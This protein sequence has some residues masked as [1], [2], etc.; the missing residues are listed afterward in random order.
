MNSYLKFLSRNKLYTAIMAVGMA[1]SLAFVIIIGSYIWNQFGTTRF[2]GAD[3]KN[4]YAIGTQEFYGATYG[5]ADEIKGKVPEIEKCARLVDMG[6]AT[7]KINGE[8]IRISYGSMDREFFEIFNEFKL[9]DGNLS[10]L[11]SKTMCLVS[12]SFAEQ[13]SL[14]IGDILNLS[15]G[16]QY[17]L[18]GIVED[19][20]TKS[21]FKA[22]EVY[23][24]LEAGMCTSVT[25]QPFD[26]FGGTLYFLRLRPDAD[27]DE[28]NEKIKTI[29]NGVYPEF[30]TES[31]KNLSLIR[32]DKIFFRKTSY[33][34]DFN[35]GDLGKL[36][37]ILAVG[38]LL[39]LSAIFNY[40][41]L[42][43]AL[44]GKRAKEMATRRLLGATKGD[45]YR[46]NIL[47]SIAF[48]AVCTIL[49]IMLAK[50]LTPT[51]NRLMNSPAVP[52]HISLSAGYL[53]AFAL[54][55][56]I[57]GALSGLLPALMA[58]KNK[59]I[60]IVKGVFRA[61]QK[62]SI[63]KIFII[64]QNA[65][66]VFLISM[67]IVMESQYRKSLNVPAHCNVDDIYYYLGWGEED[68]EILKNTL[69]ALPF[70][71][72][73]GY[74]DRLPFIK[75]SGQFSEDRYGNKIM[76]RKYMVDSLTFNMLDIEILEDFNAP[77]TN[78]VWF[79][80]KAWKASGFD[81]EHHD[82]SVLSER[83][84]GCE[85]LAGIIAGFPTSGENVGE[86]EN[87]ILV[88]CKDDEVDLGYCGLAIKTGPDHKE[89]GKTIEK[90]IEEWDKEK[91][92]MV[93]YS[94]YIKDKIEEDLRPAKN[95][96]RL[97]ELFM[98]IA[99]IIA[100][101]GLLAM[102]SYYADINTKDVAI[103]KVFGSDAGK[104]I[105]KGIKDYMIIVLLACLIGVPLAIYAAGEYLKQF[106]YKI[107]GYG[108]IF[109]VAVL[110][111]LCFAF[112][113]VFWQTRRS[114]LTEPASELKK[115]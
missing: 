76:Y 103:R 15:S 44:S 48:T 46:K 86:E 92:S 37:V 54:L 62:M 99:T 77:V 111:T 67:A 20:G 9:I 30:F 88:V 41:N 17:S 10:A 101:L 87:V 14:K 60:D 110:I 42:S 106:T 74:A 7:L 59:P 32:L 4:I 97:V 40:V 107:E 65:L 53:A 29:A 43:L 45:I 13:H 1:V 52:A 22:R 27:A 98:A 108:W 31:I 89:A 47:E 56:I 93:L 100:L 105:K 51:F 12:E 34:P 109:V 18:G 71:E 95:N 49:A 72:E 115:E 8:N 19:F 61:K 68:K 33:P 24:G 81:Q 55:A 84:Q 57:I 35:L 104:E 85:N 58:S 3:R 80:E 102:S 90:A 96:M 28:V 83:V 64:I 6:E 94:G 63:S 112:L 11:E 50:A 2:M 114:A 70:V 79:S 26:M 38:L 78:S 16:R 75:A 36:K 91:T 25:Q 82:I 73:V 23:F 66:A 21:I 69:E 5:L 39:L 113:S